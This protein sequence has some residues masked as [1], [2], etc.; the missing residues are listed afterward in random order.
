MA[1]A[2]LRIVFTFRHKLSTTKMNTHTSAALWLGH[3]WP[4]RRKAIDNEP[5]S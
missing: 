2:I 4:D 1:F 5:Y 3:I